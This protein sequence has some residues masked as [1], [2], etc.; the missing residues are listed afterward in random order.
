MNAWRGDCSDTE[1]NTYFAAT[2]EAFA[3]HNGA[4]LLV[5]AR[6][7]FR[8]DIAINYLGE[9]E[10]PQGETYDVLSFQLGDDLEVIQAVITDCLYGK[11]SYRG[12]REL[13]GRLALELRMFGGFCFKHLRDD[14]AAA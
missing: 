3:L 4:S 8:R 11:M 14:Q 13:F 1:G 6:L 9:W 10:A 2:M 5:D 7:A 12:D